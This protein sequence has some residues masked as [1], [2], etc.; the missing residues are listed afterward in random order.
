MYSHPVVSK[1]SNR[2]TQNGW[3]MHVFEDGMRVQRGSRS[4]R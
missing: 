2:A 3:S 1:S 4:G